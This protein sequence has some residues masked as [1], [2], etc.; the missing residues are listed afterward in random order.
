MKP[1]DRLEC[2]V[3]SNNYG[4]IK[5]L[6]DVGIKVEGA[7]KNKLIFI[8]KNNKPRHYNELIYSNINLGE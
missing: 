3:P 2:S 7:L 8:D 5:L 6:K 4:I 1:I